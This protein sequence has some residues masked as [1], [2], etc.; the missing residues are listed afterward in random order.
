M[1]QHGETDNYSVS[2]HIKAIFSH[3]NAKIIDIVIANNVLPNKELLQKYADENSY[4]VKIDKEEVNKLGVKLVED[5]LFK[6][7]NIY[8]RHDSEKLAKIIMKLIIV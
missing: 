1:T 6:D 5:K 2:D 4:P 3:V 7:D 8:I